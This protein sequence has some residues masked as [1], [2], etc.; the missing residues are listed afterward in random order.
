[1]LAFPAIVIP[2]TAKLHMSMANVLEISFLMY[3]M[4]GVS[5]LPW[6]IAGDKWGSRPF[7]IVF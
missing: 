6:G 1:M 4:F 5:A 7:F 3:L 2:L